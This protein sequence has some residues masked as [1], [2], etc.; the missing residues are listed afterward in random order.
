MPTPD[1]Y[2]WSPSQSIRFQ[3]CEL[4]P[5]GIWADAVQISLAPN[6][7]ANIT[8]TTFDQDQNDKLARATA[9]DWF[10]NFQLHAFNRNNPEYTFDHTVTYLPP[11]TTTGPGYWL[12]EAQVLGIPR[13][14]PALTQ[15][16]PRNGTWAQDRVY[17]N[18]EP[19]LQVNFGFN[20]NSWWDA[21]SVELT[22]SAMVTLQQ[23]VNYT[24]APR[25]PGTDFPL[26]GITGQFFVDNLGGILGIRTEIVT[27]IDNFRA[28]KGNPDK[29][30]GPGWVAFG[31]F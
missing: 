23:L 8:I 19:G 6:T 25:L 24:G 30:V 29:L 20:P 14:I 10:T 17:F 5:Q 22:I 27:D 2:W 16:E 7:V 3:K 26:Y 13:P 21:R 4:Y 31:H 28:G 9:Q 1:E 15:S 12:R 11:Q 18:D